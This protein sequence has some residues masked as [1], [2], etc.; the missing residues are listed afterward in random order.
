MAKD[1]YKKITVEV[2]KEVWISLKMM[3]LQKDVSLQHILEDIIEKSV[4]RKGKQLEVIEG[5]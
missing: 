5:N 3:S 4:S 2:R 1:E